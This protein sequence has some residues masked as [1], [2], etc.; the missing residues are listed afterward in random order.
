MTETHIVYGYRCLL[1]G[2]HKDKW[3]VG[4]TTKRNAYARHLAHK[5]GKGAPSFGDFVYELEMDGISF[6]DA[7]ERH[8]LWEDECGTRKAGEK[9]VEFINEKDS[10]MQNGFNV[11][12]N[13]Y[14]GQRIK[15]DIPKK[16]L[17]THFTIQEAANALGMGERRDRIYR[18]VELGFL[19]FMENNEEYPNLV[20]KVDVINFLATRKY[21]PSTVEIGKEQNGVCHLWVSKDLA[22]KFIGGSLPENNEN[23]EKIKKTTF[24]PIKGELFFCAFSY[25]L[26]GEE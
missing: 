1:A 16:I 15:P 22:K 18:Q 23:G 17:R 7:F 4:V 14:G 10:V 26:E 25:A 19:S 13:R 24:R 9:E 3:Y 21:S 5:R 12:I 2:E 6:D 20:P 11:R 8:L